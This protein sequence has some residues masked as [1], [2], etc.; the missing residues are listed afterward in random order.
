VQLGIIAGRKDLTAED[1]WIDHCTFDSSGQNGSIEIYSGRFIHITNNTKIDRRPFIYLYVD[2]TNLQ[3][4]PYRK[5]DNL[6]IVDNTMKVPAMD[7]RSLGTI[8]FINAPTGFNRGNFFINSSSTI[9]NNKLGGRTVLFQAGRE[10][11]MPGCTITHPPTEGSW[12]AGNELFYTPNGNDNNNKLI[13]TM[14]GTFPIAGDTAVNTF[15]GIG[16]SNYLVYTR[17]TNV[18][19]SK[20]REGNWVYLNS[21]T[22]QRYKIIGTKDSVGIYLDRGVTDTTIYTLHWIAPAFRMQSVLNKYTF[23]N[24]NAG[25]L[26]SNQNE[27][28]QQ[29]LSNRVVTLYYDATT[30]P[31]I[32]KSFYN[33]TTGDEYI[34]MGIKNDNSDT[35]KV[36]GITDSIRL[37]PKEQLH[38]VSSAPNRWEIMDKSRIILERDVN[39]LDVFYSKGK[40]S[41]KGVGG[42]YVGDN[43]GAGVTLNKRITSDSAFIPNVSNL[44][45]W[46]DNVTGNFSAGGF[47]LKSRVGYYFMVNGGSTPKISANVSNLGH[48]SFNGLSVAGANSYLDF[49]NPDSLGIILPGLSRNTFAP[50]TAVPGLIAYGNT[51]DKVLLMSSTGT[52]KPLLDSATAESIYQH[53]VTIQAPLY[54]SS[55]LITIDTGRANTQVPT[56]YDLNKV[57]DSVVTLINSTNA[58]SGM[59]F[60]VT[61]G[62]IGAPTA[63]STS[64]YGLIASVSSTSTP[65]R[66]RVYV[67]INCTLKKVFLFFNN[68][69]TLSSSETSSLYIRVNN[70]T[71]FLIS[72]AV[73]NN[74]IVTAFNN[75]AMSVSLNAGDYFEV[76]W[77]QAAWTTAPTN[78]RVSAVVWVQ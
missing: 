43:G 13:C 42:L 48:W 50:L 53:L 65:D 25:V 1:V 72:S 8:A 54:I 5:L 47:L 71:D 7:D 36:N 51:M 6:E 35:V 39:P 69:G 18:Q 3:G 40:V 23:L 76:K 49:R 63:S 46:T 33:N 12:D 73:T 20:L 59:V 29:N 11:Y 21:D 78:V 70:T 24:D 19:A 57:R 64:Y 34:Y 55:N 67:P 2:S 28:V 30:L 41:L 27:F 58:G 62:T 44:L 38:I 77:A 68:G 15:S 74:S 61:S 66:N 17:G 32:E 16:G 9:R 75:T 10:F 45:A 56:G 31:G 4:L 14:G 37:F 52:V 60:A 26:P 22:T